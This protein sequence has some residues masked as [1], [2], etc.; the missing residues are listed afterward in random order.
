MTILKLF[1]GGF[2]CKSEGLDGIQFEDEGSV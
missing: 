1:A 2:S